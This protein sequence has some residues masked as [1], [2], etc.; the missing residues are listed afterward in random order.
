MSKNYIKA[1]RLV[2][3]GY[4]ICFIDIYLLNINLLPEFIAYYLFYKAIDGID[5]YERSAHLLKPIIIILGIESLIS[6]ILVF[7]HMSIDCYPIIVIVES[8]TIYFDYQLLTNIENIMKIESND[9]YHKLGI[10]KNIHVIVYTIYVSYAILS[11]SIYVNQYISFINEY[12]NV[13]LIIAIL[14]VTLYILMILWRY[15]NFVGKVETNE[16]IQSNL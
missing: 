5:E 3:I 11:S 16:Y 7:F 8:L 13:I 6:W 15:K 10:A 12:V 2:A 4:L 9:D 1:I 14:L